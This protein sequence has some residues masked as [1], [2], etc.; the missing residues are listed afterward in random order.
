MSFRAPTSCFR[1]KAVGARNLSPVRRKNSCLDRREI[2][3][4]HRE[5]ILYLPRKIQ[6]ALDTKPKMN[7]KV[8]DKKENPPITN[9]YFTGIVLQDKDIRGLLDYKLE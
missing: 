9:K 3:N 8:K 1:K 5:K 7:G 4:D 6:K 2:F